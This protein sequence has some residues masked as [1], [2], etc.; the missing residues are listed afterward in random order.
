MRIKVQYIRTDKFGR[1]IY[2]VVGDS[3]YQI[4]IRH[5]EV[6]DA[7]ECVILKN[8]KMIACKWH[9]TRKTAK[10]WAISEVKA[11]YTNE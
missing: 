5:S 7:H 11:M 6:A 2:E 3:Q 8:D 10:G 9:P 4:T 1:F